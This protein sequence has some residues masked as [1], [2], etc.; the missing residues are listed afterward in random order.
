MRVLLRTAPFFVICLGFGMLAVATEP[1]GYVD[2][3][4]VERPFLAAE[5]DRFYAYKILLPWTYSPLYPSWEVD[6]TSVWWW[7][8]LIGALV[9]AAGR[10]FCGTGLAFTWMGLGL[11]R[12]R[13]SS[14]HGNVEIRVFPAILRCR[15]LPLPVHGG[16][17]LRRGGNG[18]PFDPPG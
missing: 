14:G 10:F 3:P 18:C 12:H 15:S 6:P 2:L 8:L 4:L 11:L 5:P 1:A 9:A 16:R 7:L 13:L 17:L